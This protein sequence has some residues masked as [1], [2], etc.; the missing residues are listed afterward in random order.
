MQDV[1]AAIAEAFFSYYDVQFVW[2][3]TRILDNRLF[4]ITMLSISYH[5]NMSIPACVTNKAFD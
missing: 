3:N 5:V 2:F 1:D 4:I